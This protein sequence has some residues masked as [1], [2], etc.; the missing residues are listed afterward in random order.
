[1]YVLF[2]YSDGGSMQ[3]KPDY[4]TKQG[5]VKHF[6]KVF[7]GHTIY[8]IA[9]NVSDESYEMLKS[10][11]PNE[12]YIQRTNYR[13]CPGSFM[14]GLKWMIEI[15]KDEDQVYMAE[16]D[17]IYTADAPQ[18][19]QEGLNIK[20]A[21]YVSG[22]DHPDKYINKADGGPNPFVSDGGEPTKVLI[23]S[24]RHW[25]YTNSCCMTFASTIQTLKEDF[26]TMNKFNSSSRS[27][28]FEM[29]LALWQ[30]N[31]KL[32]SPVPAIS[33]HGEKQL[34]SP[35]IDWQKHYESLQ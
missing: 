8:I 29:F 34:L 7:E 21:N 24:S 13:N 25:K 12:S 17:Y 9:D 32:I 33:T 5:L 4:V 14:H 10:Y 6:F 22:Y 31:R 27:C 30:K 35:F 2:R 20:Y 16:D 18:A 1:M 26:D 23:G 3:F 11:V 28:D 19:I 15:L